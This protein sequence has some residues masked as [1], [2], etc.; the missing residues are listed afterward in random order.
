M[1]KGWKESEGKFPWLRGGT[2]FRGDL[3]DPS[4]DSETPSDVWLLDSS[5]DVGEIEVPWDIVLLF[6]SSEGLDSLFAD[7]DFANLCAIGKGICS[8][9][10]GTGGVMGRSFVKSGLELLPDNLKKPFDLDFLVPP[11]V[12]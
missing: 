1:V 2:S 7:A 12:S 4:E 5:S 8:F 9:N 6:S 3:L 11:S 10:C